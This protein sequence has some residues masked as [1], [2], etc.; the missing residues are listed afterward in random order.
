MA[1]FFN[2]VVETPLPPAILQ[3]LLTPATVI[4]PALHDPSLNPPDQDLRL[5]LVYALIL[6]T[7]FLLPVSSNIIVQLRV[8]SAI[9]TKH[10]ATSSHR[11]AG[12]KVIL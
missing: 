1:V 8:P 3:S 6:F 9:G 5:V 10:L 2:E 7:V 12:H 11:T 4:Q